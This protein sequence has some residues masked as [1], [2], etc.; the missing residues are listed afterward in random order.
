M[1]SVLGKLNGYFEELI[2]KENE[3]KPRGEEVL[4]VDQEVASSVRMKLG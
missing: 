1:M 3:R 2:N 4:V